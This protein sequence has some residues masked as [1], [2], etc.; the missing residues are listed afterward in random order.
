MDTRVDVD[1]RTFIYTKTLYNIFKTL[2][3]NP[4]IVDKSKRDQIRHCLRIPSAIIRTT[5]IF[6]KSNSCCK[7]SFDAT[8]SLG[9]TKIP[10][11][12]LWSMEHPYQIGHVTCTIFDYPTYRTFNMRLGVDTLFPFSIPFNLASEFNLQL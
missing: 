10:K 4:L 11:R 12:R 3:Q 5:L 7:A 6:H 1:F 9:W 2:L 8:T